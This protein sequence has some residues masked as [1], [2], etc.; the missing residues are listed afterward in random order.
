MHYYIA[1]FAQSIVG[2]WRVLFPDFP[3]CEARGFT[4]RDAGA[5]AESALARAAQASGALPSARDLGEIKRDREWLTRHGIDFTEPVVV[6][7]IPI[8]A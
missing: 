2:E 1:I 4:V 6:R 3:E 7:M 5:V 8:A